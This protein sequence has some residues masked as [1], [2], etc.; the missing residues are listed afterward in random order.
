MSEEEIQEKQNYLRQNIMDAG[1]DTQAFVEFL[2]D[3]KG[4]AGADVANWSLPDLKNVVQEFISLNNG[5]G[6]NNNQQEEEQNEIVEKNEVNNEQNEIK[7]QPQQQNKKNQECTYGIVTKNEIHCM[8][9][10]NNEITKCDNIQITVGSFEKV[11]GNFFSKSYVTYLVT[12]APFNWNV[13]RRFSDFEWLRQTLVTNF[14]YCLIPSIPK[15]TKNLS[16]MVGEKSDNDFLSK[17]SRNFEKFLNCIIIDPI[18]KNTQLIYDFLSMEK[19]DD[20]QK[21]KKAVDKLKQPAFNISKVVTTD[22][23]ANIEINEEKEKYF[24]DIKEIT[25]QKEN[26]LKKINTTIKLLKDDLVNASDKLIDIS[27]NFNLIKENSIQYKESE[28]V[29]K[30]YSEMSSMFSNFASYLTKQKDVIFIN[31]KEYFK[32]I[33]NNYRSMKDFIHKTENLKTTF[34]KSFKSLKIKKDD[35]FRKQEV[36]KWDL[37]PKDTSIDRNTIATNKNLALNKMLYKE[38]LQVNYQKVCYGFYL[39]RIIKEHDRNNLNYSSHHH[40]H[41]VDILEIMTNNS[42]DFITSLADNST[43]MNNKQKN[44]NENMN[45]QN[46]ENNNNNIDNN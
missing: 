27:K 8:K 16:K 24:N 15:K 5:N 13:R 20:F 32:F 28:E 30:S 46:D 17:R 35:L 45:Q 42:T 18:L 23:N 25:N 36:T 40:K 39:N 43:N 29:I 21:M 22:G 31:L 7:Q 9:G 11:E 6:N 4:E 14:N 37:D 33:K 34:Y 41:C 10:L 19:D 3:K 26:I 12:T 44:E 38:T 2:I 1:Y